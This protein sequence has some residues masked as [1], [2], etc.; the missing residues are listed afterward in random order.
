M[1][2]AIFAWE[3]LHSIAVGA[4]ATHVTELAAALER[5]GNNE[6]HVF[7]RLGA[8]QATYDCIDGV[9]YHRCPI[10][11][12]SDFVTEMNNMGNSFAYFMAQTESYQ[13][14]QF[15]IVHGHE[16]LCTKGVVQTKNDRGDE[17]SSLTIR[18][19]LAAPPIVIRSRKESQ[20]SRPRARTLRIELSRRAHHWRTKSAGSITCRTKRCARFVVVFTV[21]GSI[22]PWT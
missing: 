17:W 7:V 12:H 1:K 8:G 21:P 10:E 9:H 14:A 5:R 20:P 18:R 2:I 11:L 16:W 22:G 3:S 19:S 15:D 6:V 13:G 4:V